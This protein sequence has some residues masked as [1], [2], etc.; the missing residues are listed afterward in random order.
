MSL[1]AT[2]KALRRGTHDFFVVYV[3]ESS[4]GDTAPTVVL[5]EPTT[6]KFLHEFADIFPSELHGFPQE[7]SVEHEINVPDDA[8]PSRKH[9]YRL[10][11]AEEEEVKKR[12]AEL[13]E[14]GWIQPSQSPW[15]APVLF[16]KKKD[17]GPGT[18][19][20]RFCI[21]YRGLNNV[22]VDDTYPQPV[23]E[24]L[25]ARL[26]GA[27]IFTKLDLRSG[28]HQVRIRPEDVPKTAFI[29]RYGLYEFVVMPFGLKNAPATFM[30][31]MNDVLKDFLDEFVVVYLDDILIFSKNEEEHENHVRMVLQRLREHKL[32]AKLSKCAFFQTEMEF[33]G[34]T[35]SA[36][37]IAMTDDKVKAILEWPQPRSV[38]HVRS[39][40]GLVNYYRSFIYKCGHISA[41]LSD[42][43]KKEQSFHWGELQQNAFDAL[44]LAVTSAP[45]LAL[46]DHTK[47]NYIY[48]DASALAFGAVLMQKYDKKFRPV[49][50]LSHKLDAAQRNYGVG[51][52]EFCAMKHASIKWGHYLRNNT[53]NIFITDHENLTRLASKKE[54]SG[55]FL[56]WYQEMEEH[57]GAFEIRYKPGSQNVVADALSR[58]PDHSL[59]A[60]VVSTLDELR[61]RICAAY[62]GNAEIDEIR[63]GIDTESSLYYFDDDILMIQTSNGPRIYVPNADNLREIIIS[64]HHDLRIAGHLGTQKTLLY[65]Q[66]K[67][68]WPKMKHAV[69]QYIQSCEFCQRNKSNR[70]APAGLL[71]PL[72]VPEFRWDSV[73]MDFI[74]DLPETPN[75]FDAVFTVVD[76]LS[77]MTYFI[78]TQKNITA[79]DAARLFFDNIVCVHGLPNSIISDRDPKF[80]SNFWESLWQLMGT[81]LNRSSSY[82]PQ[83]DGQTEIMNRFLN[84]YLRNFCAADHSSWDAQLKVAQF[85]YNNS[86]HSSTGYSPFF[87]N[88]GQHPNVPNQR[89][90]SSVDASS[91]SAEQFAA[92]IALVLQH[93]KS[94]LN[95]AQLRQKKF[96]DRHRVDVSFE[97]GQKVLL[98]SKNYNLK[99]T[100]KGKFLA[101][102]TGPYTV[103]EKVNDVAYKLDVPSNIH[104]VVHVSQ[105]KPY[106]ANDDDAF[107]LRPTASVQPPLYHVRG[108]AFWEI[109]RIVRR[110]TAEDCLANNFPQ[111]SN[112]FMVKYVGYPDLSFGLR[113]DLIRDIKEEVLA[114]EKENPISRRGRR[115]G[116]G[117]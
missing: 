83:T 109:E 97:V 71:Q 103:V 64:E 77:K 55:K 26:Q 70:Q 12:I 102:F 85:A 23:A 37:G 91:D 65:I 72:P 67:Y 50:F 116:G 15:A 92:D 53:R 1:N 89:I 47:D 8:K 22:T 88:Y 49:C 41:P 69:K 82:H 112:G 61:K 7:R 117:A 28:Y 101:K 84:D 10:S 36:A 87:L 38:T 9:A 33:L 13:L 93:A 14:A 115:R 79:Q 73:S 39:F 24:D 20:L 17:A 86:V 34:H 3:R 6:G 2:K 46:H 27:T 104:N 81:Q 78:A 35:L 106:F 59:C 111:G 94:C 30:R 107:P 11:H 19:G 62:A 100:G 31:L 18:G 74:V 66:R 4:S 5:T 90:R 25:F 54:L 52:L 105:L 57:A 32:Y 42:L 75:G 21:D 45:V 16:A 43:T 60:I 40:L 99:G 113:S 96:A 108:Q 110:A 56:R 44:K 95:E 68:Y 80:V 76:R 48:T 98:N 63:K 114:F 29:T 58:R 51:E